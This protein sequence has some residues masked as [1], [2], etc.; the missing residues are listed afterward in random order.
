MDNTCNRAN[1]TDEELV[2]LSQN[3]DVE[4]LN[5]VLDRYKPMVRGKANT[6]FLM[7]ADSEDL[8]QEG[9][10]GLFLALREYKSD[11]NASFKTFAN[12][13]VSGQMNKAIEAANRNK[14]IPLNGYISL[15]GHDDASGEEKVNNYLS[16][17]NVDNPE[18][19]Y[20]DKEN[21]DF[22]MDRIQE[23]LS[24]MEWTVFL[25]YIEGNNYRSIA[26]ELDKSDK[27]IDNALHRIKTKI[28]NLLSKI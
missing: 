20:I 7:G 24:P 27:S 9:M 17:S 8:I 23:T 26:K 25:K 19:L 15:S 10:I 21:V 4:A 14:H 13:C 18:N 3:G 12:L 22:L 6:L 11:K 2:S 16:D 28:G 1:F 5:I